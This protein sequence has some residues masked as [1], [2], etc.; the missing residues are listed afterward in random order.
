MEYHSYISRPLSGGSMNPARTI[1]PALA[2]ATY[3]GIWVY[4]VGPVIGTI[5]GAYT[6]NLI[7]E[8]D[9]PIYAISQ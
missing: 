6:Y 2:S 4:V 8:S 5:L 7:R 1:G 9:K 3:K